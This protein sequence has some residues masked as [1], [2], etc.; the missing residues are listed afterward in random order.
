MRS[1]GGLDGAAKLSMAGETVGGALKTSE[2]AV[3]LA[4]RDGDVDRALI[5][6][7]SA[8]LRGIFRSK[9]GRVPV[10]CL[11]GVLTL[12]DG[13][14]VLSPLRLELREAIAIGAGKID[15]AKDTL[16]LTV[17][18]ERDSTNFF[19]LDIPVHI[20][21][22]F[23]RLSV[24]PLGGSDEAWLE[25]ASANADALPPALRKLANGNPCQD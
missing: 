4:M 10:T 21:G 13:I 24:V 11:L 15:L 7:L 12:K 19:A 5:E 17:K 20:S 23:D 6:A 14:G 22:P 9:E 2:G 3:V 25:Q 8:D 16:D 1:A 18:T